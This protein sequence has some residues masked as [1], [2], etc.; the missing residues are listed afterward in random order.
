LDNTP[1]ADIKEV[2]ALLD[3]CLDSFFALD[4]VSSM[5]DFR[6]WGHHML[7]VMILDSNPI[8]VEEYRQQLKNYRN[9]FK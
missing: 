2:K 9:T 3:T 7:N 5:T 6:K 1:P 4:K 8:L